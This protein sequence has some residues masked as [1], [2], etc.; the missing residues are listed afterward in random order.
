M[1]SIAKFLSEYVLSAL[2]VNQG[3]VA[4]LLPDLITI[5]IDVATGDHRL[6]EDA[7]FAAQEKADQLLRSEGL[8]K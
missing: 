6:S 2:G 4:E 1:N 8:I 7:E 5:G 3:A